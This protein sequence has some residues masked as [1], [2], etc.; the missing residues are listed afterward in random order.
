[1]SMF[2]RNEPRMT[3]QPGRVSCA[4]RD[5][6]ERLGDLLRERRGDRDRRHRAHEQERRDDDGLVGAVVLQ[7][8]LDHAV[9]PAQRRVAVHQRDDDRRLPRSPRA[10]RTRCRT[11]ASVSRGALGRDDAA[12]E[13][14]VGERQQ[15]EDHVE[16]ARVERRVVRLDDGAAG[17]VELV[18]ATGRAGRSARSRA[19]W[20]RAARRPRARTAGRRRRRSPC[21]RR[22][23]G[24]CARGC[25]PARRTRAA[26]WPPAPARSR[27]RGRRCCSSTRWPAPRNSVE[28]LGVHELDAELRHDAAPA[29]VERR[30][31]RPP[32]GSRSGASG[33]RTCLAP[34]SAVLDGRKAIVVSRCGRR[35]HDVGRC[36]SRPRRRGSRAID[37]AAALLVAVIEADAPV[38]PGELAAREALP[39]STTAARSSPRWSAGASCSATPSGAPA[40]GPGAR[41]LRPPRRGRRRPRRARRARAAAAGR[42]LAAR[43]STSSCRGAT[44]VE[45]VAQVDGRFLLGGANWVGAHVPLPRLRGRQ[46]VP[47]LRACAAMPPAA[48]RGS[49]PHHHDPRALVARP[50]TVRRRGYA[51]MVDELEAGLAAVGAPACALDRRGVAALTRLRAA[52][53]GSPTIDSTSSAPLLVAEADRPLRPARLPG[54]PEGAA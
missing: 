19:A 44:G 7:R 8:R 9:V 38:G 3:G 42:A 27:G 29:A 37:R 24:C 14:L 12:H 46:G 21:G 49:R 43:P 1:M 41:R 54:A 50:R 30:R 20:R 16:V 40:P 23:G 4:R 17:G 31:S 32:R 25:A 28:R 22:R 15:P 48:W 33:S 10:R 47:G 2:E 26:P 39:R 36:A 5:A 53:S 18:E 6:G 51:A 34:P 13:R 11:C 45:C 52:R 35:I